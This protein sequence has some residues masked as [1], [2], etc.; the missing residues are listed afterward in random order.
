MPFIFI[1]T[2]KETFSEKYHNHDI[3]NVNDIDTIN[4]S[5]I[6]ILSYFYEEEMYNNIITRYGNKYNIHRIYNGDNEPLD[7]MVYLDIYN[8]LL[9]LYKNGRR[10]IMFINTPLH[11]NI[12]D[13]IIAY[14]TMKF[15]KNS[16]LIMTS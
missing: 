6:V 1:D 8:R 12:G 15:L 9:N 5:E 11:T 2:Y 10:R 3:I 4:I 14:A 16:C 7:P 13:H